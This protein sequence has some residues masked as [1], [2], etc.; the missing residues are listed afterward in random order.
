MPLHDHAG[1]AFWIQ[2]YSTLLS[3]LITIAVSVCFQ[4][5]HGSVMTADQSVALPVIVLVTPP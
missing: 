2:K 4:C 1:C 3:S 5:S